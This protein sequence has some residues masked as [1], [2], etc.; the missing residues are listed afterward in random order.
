MTAQILDGK[1]TAAAIKAEL[2]ERVAALQAKGIT[3][4]LGTILVGSDPG[5]TWYVGGKHKDCAEVGIKSIRVDLP[6]ETTQ[7]ELLAKVRELNENPECTGYIVQLPLPAHI[8]QDVILEA[9]DPAKD[10]DGLHPMNLG[11]LVANVNRPMTSPLPCTPKG[12]V[13]LLERHGIDLNGKRVLVVGRGVT[14]GRPIG[15]LLTRRDINATVVLA[16]TGTKDLAA[17]LAAA[18]VV[19]AAAGSAHM[20]KAKDLK[21][22]AIVLDVGVSRVNDE[23]G[24]AV[25]TGDVEPTASEVASWISPNPGGVGPMTRAMLLA[26]VVESAERAAGL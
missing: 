2:T 26:N 10:A 25:V 5:S 8:D 23:N 9:M 24:K 13:V 20:I 15:L 4:G 21:P 6:E 17:E 3:P 18:D 1:A 16:H 11:R 7:D 14:I 12:C 22:G 19:V